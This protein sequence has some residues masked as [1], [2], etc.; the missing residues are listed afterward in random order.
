MCVNLK[1]IYIASIRLTSDFKYFWR[2]FWQYDVVSLCK[3]EIT[4][5]LTDI[6][7]NPQQVGKMS[8]EEPRLAIGVNQCDDGSSQINQLSLRKIP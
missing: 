4:R 3:H 8:R 7:L 5:T 2:T 1:I 6:N